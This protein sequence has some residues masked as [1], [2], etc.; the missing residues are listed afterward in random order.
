[1]KGI[2]HLRGTIKNFDWGGFSFLPSLLHLE[3]P[4]KTS[5]AEYWI[6]THSGG[7]TF[8]DLGNEISKPLE[9]VAGSFSY[10]FKILDVNEMLSIQV[11]PDRA[12]A[13]SEYERENR[14]G[15]AIDDPRRNYR[16]P[17]EKPELM[18]ALG[19]FW[20]LHGFK[21]VEAMHDILINI[22]ELNE[23][24]PVFHNNGYKGLY[25]TVM[26]MPQQEVNRML[27][28]LSDHILPQYERGEL[29][30]D[31]EDF[32]AAKALG[33]FSRN[34]QVD[35]GIF[36]I[37][38]FNLLKLEKGEGIF[39][40]PG[41]PHAYLQGQNVEIMGNSDNVLRGGLTTKHI[42]I[43]ELMKHVRFEATY[44]EILIPETE[45]GEKVYKTPASEF[46]LSVIEV[47]AGEEKSWHSDGREVLLLTEG[48]AILDEQGKCLE[49]A[50]GHPASLVLPGQDVQLKAIEPS[51]IFKA[52]DNLF[53]SLP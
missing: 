31:T 17:N 22:T 44:P 47:P 11:H 53:R 32:W 21:P 6:G 29:T 12:S 35:R 26:E 2:Y 10:L 40:P 38:F 49:L 9:E 5:F 19:E 25:K 37:Y 8:V 36:S 41:I 18:V 23:L 42:D 3:N 30:R 15:I 39:Q 48:R 16:D 51:L 45:N 33:S 7:K 28:P 50:P 34:N 27:Q 24:L 52:T 13:R 4:G 46:R 14:E 20:L 1:M 43:A